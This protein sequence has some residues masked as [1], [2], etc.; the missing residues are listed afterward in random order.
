MVPQEG[1]AKKTF[2][3]K[4]F[5]ACHRF[6]LSQGQR[7]LLPVPSIQELWL[8]HVSAAGYQKRK[9][10]WPPETLYKE[11]SPLLENIGCFKGLCK[12]IRTCLSRLCGYTR[13]L[14]TNTHHLPSKCGTS[15]RDRKQTQ[16]KCQQVWAGAS[17]LTVVTTPTYTISLSQALV[18]ASRVHLVAECAPGGHCFNMIMEGVHC[19]RKRQRKH[20]GSHEVLPQP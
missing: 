2:R 6:T 20:S 12:R 17:H 5:H 3:Q 11:V 8:P 18:T 16:R 1:D 9:C 13:A 15:E 7:H 19:Q 10:S 4:R 14:K